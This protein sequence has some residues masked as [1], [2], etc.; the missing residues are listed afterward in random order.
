MNSPLNKVKTQ[1]GFT[2]IELL[3]TVLIVAVL[4]SV[5]LPMTHL[6]SQR[7]KEAQLR[8][9]LRQIRD[10]IDAYKRAADSG[11]IVLK[12]GES[13]YPASLDVLVSGVV[14]A[15]PGSPIALGNLG[16]GEKGQ[17]LSASMNTAVIP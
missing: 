8:E 15:K 12:S 4:A 9:A 1:G 7:M 5:A 17:S 10:A 14:D 6:A 13:G 3:M 11:H 2:L 16:S